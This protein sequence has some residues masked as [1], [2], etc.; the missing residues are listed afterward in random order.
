MFNRNRVIALAVSAFCLVAIQGTVGAAIIQ[1][2][3]NLNDNLVPTGFSLTT[4]NTAGLSNGRLEATAVNGSTAL[5]YNTL[6]SNLAQVDISYRARFGYSF[7]GT[8]TVVSLGGLPITLTHGA[9]EFTHGPNNFATIGGGG[10]TTSP[11]NFST[12]EYAI[13]VVDGQVSFTGTDTATNTQAFSLVHADAGILLA[14]IN[15]ISFRSHN[16]TGTEPV[17]LDDIRMQLHTV[18]VPAPGALLL[19]GLGIAGLGYARRNRAA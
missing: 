9:N 3:E 19:F 11:F 2:D 4:T 12:F 8:Y 16:T 6:P 17:W 1:V 7:W 14:N 15:Q 18:E 10:T 13:T 5:A